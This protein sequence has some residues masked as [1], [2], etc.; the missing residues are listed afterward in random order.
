MVGIIFPFVPVLNVKCATFP[1][2]V[3]KGNI[4]SETQLYQ[5]SPSVHEDKTKF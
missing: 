2:G 4:P 5:N 3:E 1:T